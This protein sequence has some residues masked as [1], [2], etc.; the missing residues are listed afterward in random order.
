MPAVT[1]AGAQDGAADA[2]T[3][4]GAADEGAPDVVDADVGPSPFEIYVAPTGNDANPGTLDLPLATLD[5]ARL[6]VQNRAA[7]RAGAYRVVLRAGT[8]YLASTL[9]LTGAD[10]GQPGTPVTYT[11]YPRER[12]IVSG[13]MPVTGFVQIDAARNVWRAHV[14]VGTTSRQLYVDGARALRARTTGG[15]AAGSVTTQAP[16]TGYTTNDTHFATWQHPAGVELVWTGVPHNTGN[17]NASKNWT[18]SRCGVASVSGNQVL[19][20][21]PC[22]T[23]ASAREVLLPTYFENDPSFLDAPGEFYLDG[24]AGTLDYIPLPGQDPNRVKVI[25][26]LLETLLRAE[27]TAASPVHDL[28]FSGLVFAHGTWRGP[29]DAAGFP[30]IQ[31]NVYLG[32]TGASTKVPAN[33]VFQGSTG[34]Q[35]EN[36]VFVHLGGAGLSFEAGSHSNRV[37]GNQFTDISSAAISLADVSDSS[38]TDPATITSDIT[39][40]NNFIHDVGVEYHGAVGLLVLFTKGTIL[41]NNQLS[42]LP[43]SGISVG[44]HHTNQP[45]SLSDTQILN[46]LIFDVVKVVWDGGGIYDL[47]AQGPSLEHGLLVQ[48]N[49][50]HTQHHTNHLAYTDDGSQ[51]VTLRGNAFYD[52]QNSNDWGG[53]EPFG[54][55]VFDG[56]Y[57]D[58]DPAT[59]K[60]QPSVCTGRYAGPVRLSVTGNTLITDPSAIP[61]SL[62]D[63][64][65]VQPAYQSLGVLLPYRD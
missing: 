39:V 14:P 28:V 6:L 29:D 12:A 37:V 3:L 61:T 15:F 38:L 50:V 2:I 55:I 60:S 23:H 58:E 51:Y 48:G 35:V 22:F 27:G 11:S 1:Q 13:G 59:Q 18:E 43:Y 20:D 65:G 8:Y 31:A 56:N 24:A 54:D 46:N 62:V 16:A 21:Q 42:S 32:A 40:S 52:N 7:A 47:G 4:D 26:P 30:E 49:V 63:A 9:I 17:G 45:S 34:I 36:S 41:S 19:I 25:I 53:C 57:E 10:S 44:F 5:A 64:A 33:V